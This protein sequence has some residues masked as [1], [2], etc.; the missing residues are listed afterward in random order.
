M[1]EMVHRRKAGEGLLHE[2]LLL[3]SNDKLEVAQF[4]KTV[5]ICWSEYKSN[6]PSFSFCFSNQ[7]PLKWLL[8]WYTVAYTLALTLFTLQPVQN[9]LLQISSTFFFIFFMIFS[10]LIEKR[11]KKRSA[12]TLLWVC[13]AAKHHCLILMSILQ[14]KINKT[15]FFHIFPKY[16]SLRKRTSAANHRQT[17]QLFYDFFS[18]KSIMKIHTAAIDLFVVPPVE[19]FSD[20]FPL[21]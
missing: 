3:G 17:T 12:I 19:K 20:N 18:W 10:W 2:H 13:L 6:Y 4:I 1:G 16:K 15:F 9:T 11:L 5:H 7:W 8:S 21:E 14:N